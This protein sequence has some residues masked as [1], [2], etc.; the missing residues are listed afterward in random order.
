MEKKHVNRRFFLR[1]LLAGGVLGS[2]GSPGF[3]RLVLGMG[4]RSY[5]QGMQQVE[6]DVRINGQPAQAGSTVKIGDVVTTGHPKS[7][8]VFVAG[9][10]AYLLRDNSRLE[11]L[12]SVEG[13]KTQ[14]ADILRL[15]S[16]KM[17]AVFKPGKKNILTPTAVIGVRGTGTYLEVEEARTYICT[18]YGQI[19]VQ[20]A[21]NTSAREEL[22]STHHENAR[23]IYGAGEPNL[24]IAKAP[25]VNHTD[26]ELI[27]LESLVGRVPPFVSRRQS[28]E[29]NGSG[30][31]G[32]TY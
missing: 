1:A 21:G 28:D 30:N 32:K 2:V 12:A 11:V 22:R 29:Q 13:E 26:A 19:D 10:D 5:P 3:V 23:Y 14:T 20:A 6:G 31:G 9:L 27:M 25:M 15:V 17:L 7:L 18:C 4:E 8:A 16:G 24:L